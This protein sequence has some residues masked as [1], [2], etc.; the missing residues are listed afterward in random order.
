MNKARM[1]KT[2]LYIAAAFSVLVASSDV[3]AT[4]DKVPSMETSVA[5]IS[6][7]FDKYYSVAIEED[8]D[9]FEEL[10]EQQ[11]KAVESQIEVNTASETNIAGDLNKET[12]EQDDTEVKESEYEHTGISIAPNYVNV[13]TEANTDSEAVGKLYK[14][15]AATITETVGDWVKIKSGKVK[16]YIKSE[17]LAI[18][19]GAEKLVEKYG[20]RTATVEA[21]TL[22]VREEKNTEC[23]TL[24]LIPQGETYG[25][26][27]FDDEWVE[28]EV[29]TDITGF[30]SREFVKMNVEFP[31]AI[32][33]EE[34][35]EQ[36]RLE[37]E[38]IEAELEA[39]R[40]RLANEKAAKQEAERI[41]REKQRAEEAKREEQE[42]Q[43]PA[44]T[45][46]PEKDDSEEEIEQ[47]DN[48]SDS[49]FGKKVANLALK[50]VG[51]RYV[52]GGNSL[53]NGTDCSG[54]TM[55]IYKQFGY[56]IPRTSASQSTYG[57]KVS[58]GSLKAGDLIF[59]KK[60]GRVNHV[61]MYIGGGR[62]V[63]AST[64]RTGI[65]TANMYYRTPSHAR[66]IIR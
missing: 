66:R 13:R 45:K 33:I 49:S 37:Q 32:S 23:K 8:L 54:F 58:L 9:V 31:K 43:K 63:H 1:I 7:S 48:S 10:I 55:L 4:K 38:R 35:L 47:P 28:I 44:E 41:K 16:G 34:E 2:G 40:I 14:G 19:F 57:T 64:R 46:K 30:I 29:D 61:A 6:L 53:T 39:E 12:K 51:N 17:Y 50:Y 52:Y 36:Q 24:T 59:Y 60:N 56:N 27:S 42:N 15:S 62:V 22:R 65:I 20:T 26:I 21:V 5:G 25:V 11:Q 3:G 18:G